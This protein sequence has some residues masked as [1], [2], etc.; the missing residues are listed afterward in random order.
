M[1]EFLQKIQLKRIVSIFNFIKK[2]FKAC[3][4][5]DAKQSSFFGTT[6]DMDKDPNKYINIIQKD[7]I[8]TAYILF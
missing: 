5:P 4:T 3:I 2:I 6:K 1:Y 7:D 8:I